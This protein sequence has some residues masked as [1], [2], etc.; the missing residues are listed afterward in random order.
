ML[1][2]DHAYPGVGYRLYQKYP[3]QGTGLI[4]ILLLLYGKKREIS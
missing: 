4:E 1:R 3:I 2:I